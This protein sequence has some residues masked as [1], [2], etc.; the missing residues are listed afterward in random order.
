MQHLPA[1]STH[2]AVA[3]V[4]VQQDTLGMNAQEAKPWMR[5]QAMT[6]GVL[7]WRCMCV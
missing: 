6:V 2:M 1:C 7:C 5:G 4:S 3:D